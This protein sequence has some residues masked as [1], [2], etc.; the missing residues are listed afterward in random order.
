VATTYS[1][2]EDDKEKAEKIYKIMARRFGKEPDVWIQLGQFYFKIA[3]LK[4][5]R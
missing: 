3:N 5:A 2:N 1:Q 4:D